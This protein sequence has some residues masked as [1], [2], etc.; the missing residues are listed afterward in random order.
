MSTSPGH[1]MTDR[2]QKL[3]TILRNPRSPINVESLLT[4]MVH[5][6]TAV[7]TPD[8][9]SPEVLK[10]QGGDGYYGRECDWWSVGV[11]LFEMLVGDTP[12]YADSLVGTYSKIMDHKNS[13]NF[14]EDVEISKNAKNLICA[15]LTD[16]EVR[17]GRNGIEEIKQHPF[18]KNDQWNWESIR[19]TAAP[20]V[21]ELSSDVDSSNFDE[22]E[23]DKGD[24]ETF[25]TPKAFVG[26]QL[27]FIG[28]TY[29]RENLLLSASS[30]TREQNN[31]PKQPMKES[32]QLQK[33]LHQ[34]EEQ[35]HNEMQAK[36]ELEQKY[37][38][39]NSRLEKTMKELDEEANS[40]KNLE[41][42]S[43]QLER[44]KALLQ[45]KNAEYQRKAENEAEKKRGLENEVN[46]LKDQLEDLKKRNQ[47]SQISNE[48]MNQLQRQLDEANALLRTESDTAAR[49]RKT[50]TEMSKQIQQLETN[51]RELQDKSCMLEN[52]KLK[53][54]KD[55][56]NQQSALESERRDRTHGS[57]MISDLQEKR[58]Q[59]NDIV[60]SMSRST[61]PHFMVWCTVGNGP[62]P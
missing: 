12:F 35:L 23:D 17:L 34:L 10:S 37:R 31:P 45:H 20:V 15:F 25:P 13:L 49:L 5:C 41:S 62:T 57:E 7:G 59:K 4:G 8:Y 32:A 21:P 29:Y 30:Q 19:D 60:H 56:I 14:P 39:V 53:L 36:D 16:R 1:C 40:R 2:Q 27:P 55:F 26:N 43:R 28:F 47:S 54:E 6:D 9:I 3:E 58:K 44:E 61:P 42:T 50:Q 11:F 24:V 51:S 22:I 38:S 52:A 46:S 33:K 18:F 48:K